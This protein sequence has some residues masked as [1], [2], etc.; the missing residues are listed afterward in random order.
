MN[1]VCSP[2]FV[3]KLPDEA[4]R[5]LQLPP[6]SRSPKRSPIGTP[7]S[8]ADA[9]STGSPG[10]SGRRVSNIGN[11]SDQNS[12]DMSSPPQSDWKGLGV[13]AQ[14]EPGSPR[15]VHV[16]SSCNVDSFSFSL[17]STLFNNLIYYSTHSMSFS[18]RQRKWKEELD[19]ELERKRGRFFIS[20]YGLKLQLYGVLLAIRLLWSVISVEVK[21]PYTTMQGFMDWHR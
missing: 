19:Q 1:I 7:S 18:E 10:S 4:T 21:V 17:F 3:D 9:L 6:K 2:S 12:K 14:Q 5:Y 11:A 16:S 8:V 20:F 15:L 13:D